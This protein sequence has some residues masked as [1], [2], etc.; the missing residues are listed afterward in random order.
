MKTCSNCHQSFEKLYAPSRA[1]CR[2]CYKNAWE[3][4]ARK[5]PILGERI[6]NR[7][8]R[9][10]ENNKETAK[11]TMKKYREQKHF[12]SKRTQVLQAHDYTCTK[13]HKL[14]AEH[15]LIVHH[16]DRQGRGTAQPNNE[17]TNLTL[18]CRGC[19]AKEHALELAK[20]R[21]IEVGTEAFEWSLNYPCCIECGTTARKH[22][23]RGKCA[24]CYKRE[25]D[26]LKREQKR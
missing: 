20:A 14:Y 11:A 19:H 17:D 9:V 1:L 21:G 16:I 10:Y 22:K 7:Q 4:E 18:L 3:K 8:K 24:N 13:C 26:K 12:D 6:R 25:Y 5:D 15:Q 2:R 23:A